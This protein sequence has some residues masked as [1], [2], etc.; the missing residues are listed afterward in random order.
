MN[1]NKPVKFGPIKTKNIPLVGVLGV[2]LISAG[3]FLASRAYRAPQVYFNP[4]RRNNSLSN[5]DM[6]LVEANEY[7]NGDFKR[8]LVDMHTRSTADVFPEEEL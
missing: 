6:Q 3:L 7:L 8:A 1:F 2:S 4:E 5:D